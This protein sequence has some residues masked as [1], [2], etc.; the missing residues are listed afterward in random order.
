VLRPYVPKDETPGLLAGAGATLILLDDLALGVMSPSKLHSSLAMG[1]PVLYIGPAG[2]N[3]DEA[4]TRFGC[5]LAFRQDD[6]DGVVDAVRRLRDE[7]TVVADLRRR[8]RTA[9]E[10]AYADTVALTA[11]DTLLGH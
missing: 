5:G 10:Q 8:A 11:W 4:I 9:F 7:P 6:V 3:V 1:V 2:S